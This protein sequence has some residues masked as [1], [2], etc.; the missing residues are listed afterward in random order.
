MLH[1]V[2]QAQPGMSTALIDR[3]L[4]R[5]K[6]RVRKRAD[7]HGD[8]SRHPVALPAHGA[9]ALAAEQEPGDAAAVAGLSVFP[10]LPLDRPR[11][12]RDPPRHSPPAAP[13]LLAP[14]SM[15]TRPPT[16]HHTPT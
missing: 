7:R 3:H 13:S 15:A 11:I 6:I 1:L 2:R 16:R 10:A 9:P 14:A 4:R 5:R 8:K 12:R